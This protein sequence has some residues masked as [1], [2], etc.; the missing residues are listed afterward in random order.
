MTEINQWLLPDGIEDVLPKQAMKMESLRRQALDLFH[1]WGYDLVVPPLVE[2]TESLLSGTGSDLDLMTFKLTDQV[3]GRAMGVRADM[4]P[5]TSRM[6]AHSLK[7]KGP[8]RLCYAGPVLYTKPRHPLESR[9]PIQIGIE[10]YGESGLAADIEVIRL[11]ME[12]L[13]LAGLK[14]LRLDI[15]HVGIY[16]SLLELLNLSSQKEKE[17]FNLVQ[18]KSIPQLNIWIDSNLDNDV[19]AKIIQS[20]VGLVGDVS[21]LSSAR[22]L[23]KD[24]PSEVQLA[25]DELQSVA[26]ALTES[27]PNIEICFD[28]SELRGYHYHTGLVFAVYAPG[29]GQAIG[30]GGRYDHV[31]KSFGRSRPATGFN[32]S[33]KTLVQLNKNE[34]LVATGI[35]APASDQSDQHLAIEKLRLAGNRVVM[36]FQGQE[37]NFHELG[38]DRQLILVG[39][40]FQVA[41]I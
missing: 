19:Y 32:M 31:G 18:S 2:F 16:E 4:T 20:L 26:D 39:N 6:D 37:A 41:P 7:R 21:I 28:L 17:L 23:L 1:S 12:T 9:S 15:G 8:S 13:G 30:N 29:A 10:L 25:L 22:T 36:G 38:C 14:N 34:N 33:L 5:Q 40:E 24:A 27:S 35:F 3:S 11:M